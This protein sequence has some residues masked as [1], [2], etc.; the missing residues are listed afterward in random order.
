MPFVLGIEIGGTKL[1]L[2]IGDGRSSKLEQ[3]CRADID[4]Q[5]G[6]VGIVAQIESLGQE[7]RQQYELVGVGIGFGGPVDMTQGQV[8]KSHQVRGWEGFPLRQHFEQ[9][10]QI[11]VVIDN[12]CNVAALAEAQLGAGRGRS[13]V[14]YVTVGSGIGGGFVIDGKV[15]G[16]HRP[17]ISEIGH[18]RPGPSATGHESTVES[19]ASGWGISRA[20][21]AL[22]R[23]QGSCQDAAA[24]DLRSRCQGNLDSLSTKMIADAAAA[25]NPLATRAMDDAQRA[26]GWAIG[27]VIT[28]LGPET[29]VV[30]GGVS[31]IGDAFFTPLREHVDR[32]CFPPLRGTFS[33]VPAEL[34]EEVVVHGAVLLAGSD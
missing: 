32:Y 6:A 13:R 33:V 3:L 30:G 34:G 12:D 24:D 9:R 25:G 10:W 14:F 4:V 11:P 20:A 31:L 7:L 1:Q 15:D 16:N 5:R 17:A 29:V 8:T 27:Q 22:V 21:R 19:V 28:L 18:L 26:L 2:G 23:D